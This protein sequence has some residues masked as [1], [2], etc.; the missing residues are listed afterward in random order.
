LIVSK[1]A[2]LL[3]HHLL[4]VLDDD[5]LVVAVNLLTGEVVADAGLWKF[6]DDD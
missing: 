2:E 4:A 3:H 6:S 5:A 1:V